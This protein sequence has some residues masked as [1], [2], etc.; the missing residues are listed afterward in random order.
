LRLARGRGCVCI[1]DEVC[2]Y[3][4]PISTRCKVE[5]LSP[6]LG[7]PIS[8][9][10]IFMKVFGKLEDLLNSSNRGGGVHV[11]LWGCVCI[12]VGV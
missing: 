3:H 12:F 8:L 2:I 6:K 11:Y 10:H 4:P 9:A 5:F 7:E 1:L